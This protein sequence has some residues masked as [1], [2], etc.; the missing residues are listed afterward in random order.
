MRI[1]YVLSM[2]LKRV[3]LIAETT[4]LFS[5]QAEVV[6]YRKCLASQAKDSALG[7]NVTTPN[8]LVEELWEVWGSGERLVSDTQRRLI[9]RQLLADQD[10]WVDSAG[11]VDLL[12]S[13]VRDFITYL[14]E[15][16]IAA[17]QDE[18]SATDEQIIRFVRCYEDVLVQTGL[19]E[20]AQAV[21][22][23]EAQV[24]L[25][26]CVIRT[27]EELPGYLMRFF[28]HIVASLTIAPSQIGSAELGDARG[29]ATSELSA[30]VQQ[31]PLVR[32]LEPAGTTAEAYALH[33][34]L[35]SPDSGS[36]VIITAYDP[37]HLFDQSAEALIRE[38]FIVTLNTRRGF[39]ETL[40]GQAFCA[41]LMLL[42]D[43]SNATHQREVDA[44]LSYLASPF[45]LVNS[46][47]RAYVARMIRADRSLTREGLCDLLRSTSRSF[48]L[49]EELGAESDADVLFAYFRDLTFQL[50]LN[51]AEQECERTVIDRLS[52]LYQEARMLSLGP[53]SFIDL[54][55]KISV[56]FV[57]TTESA[58]S[59][60][61]EN[62]SDLP[63]FLEAIQP[64]A[65]WAYFTSLEDAAALPQN[66]CDALIMTALDSGHYNGSEKRSTLTEFLQRFDLP[67]PV[68]LRQ[69]MAARF[70]RVC[71][72]ARY[73]IVFEHA[74][75]NIDGNEHYAAFF[76]EEYLNECALEERDV[77]VV[78]FGEEDFALHACLT[79]LTDS[80][81][82][83]EARVQP[84]S[85]DSASARELV[86]FGRDAEGMMRPI[87]SASALEKYRSCPYSWFIER[88]LRLE[89]VEET[90]GPREIGTF[91]H[92]LF[93]E[94]FDQ[95]AEQ[96][97][98]RVTSLTY[99]E[100]RALFLSL[101]DRRIA[102]QDA[103]AV[104]DRL[105]A[106][107][108][109]EREKIE[110]LKQQ[111][112]TALS[113]QQHLFSGY[114]VH[115]HEIAIAPEEAIVYGGAIINGRIDRID[116]DDEGNFIVIDYKG[117]LADY[118]AGFSLPDEGEID[119]DELF[120]APDKVQAL[121]YAQVLRKK[122]PALTPKGAVYM[123]YR[124]KS[125][126][127]LLAGSLSE[128]LAESEA[129]TKKENVVEGS[130]ER[131]LDLVEEDLGATI[132]HMVE[133][134]IAPD[135]RSAASCRYCPVLYCE[136][137]INGS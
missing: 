59:D 22:C 88:K 130:F 93:Q 47:K 134:V 51:E 40:F 52:V 18:F 48:E 53:R 39:R 42:D 124:P 34:E 44:A 64:P 137:R 125:P 41:A 85:L 79:E 37:Q 86:A 106:I 92:G 29:D 35:I 123:S 20:G 115:G 95:L 73:K 2:H 98:F 27:Q 24:A 104:G 77:E 67:L 65:R 131:Y 74:Q 3:V 45:S 60:L 96:G 19:I 15:D 72:L 127:E 38:G 12:A 97:R 90:F 105:I 32:L 117:S 82:H 91:V 78:H 81:L 26:A 28:E 25:P 116:V 17:H 50:H 108:Q 70:D 102:E 112:T 94:F 71:R 62:V 9:I 129:F 89:E 121:I 16:F 66:C 75:Q 122:D 111:L 113:Y 8:A 14:D 126:K 31:E 58:S 101:F 120:E 5:T 55:Q 30:A 36:K 49:F 46:D 1:Q 132:A 4:I 63:A 84:G 118:G 83:S 23:L 76:L 135:P 57:R 54:A 43:S 114:R 119:Q 100:D 68:A 7:V 99:E 103:L 21:Q 13:F 128:C 107:D 87:I 109:L 33:R 80:F 6:R 133:G 10:D 61:A 69:A 11:T 110:Q 136:K 56:S